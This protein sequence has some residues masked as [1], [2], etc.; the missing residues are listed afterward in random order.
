MTTQE[1]LDNINQM[2]EAKK[3]K[4]TSQNIYQREIRKKEQGT[5][6]PSQQDYPI[7]GL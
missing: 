5:P 2:K 6:H 1:Y 7:Y 4:K 3:R